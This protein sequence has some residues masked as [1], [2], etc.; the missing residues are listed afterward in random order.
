MTPIDCQIVSAQVGFVMELLVFS[1]RINR[2]YDICT[3]WSPCECLPASHST[4]RLRRYHN[5]CQEAC[6]ITKPPAS[7]QKIQKIRPFQDQ[8]FGE[9]IENIACIRANGGF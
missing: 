2:R 8:Y 5:W 1:R 9:K 4:L 6:G 7:H 3:K